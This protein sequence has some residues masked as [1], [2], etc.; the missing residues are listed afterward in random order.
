[1]KLFQVLIILLLFG[2]SL[3][4]AAGDHVFSVN[5]NK[6]YLNDTEIIVAGLRCSNALY[7]KTSTNDLI[8]HLDQYKSYGVNTV[9]VFI[10]GSRYGNF[11]G[12]LENGSLNP[13]HAKRL[14]KII[15]AADKRGMIVIV[16]C[17]YWGGSTAKWETWTQKDA[18]TAIAN[19]VKWL[20]DNNFRN[21]FI[22]VDNEGMAKRE[23]G[24]NTLE[25]VK[26]AKAI[27]SSFCVATNFKG[28][29]PK[30]ADLGIHFSAK[31]PAKPY[32][33]SEGTPTN[34]PGNYWGKYSK[35]PPLENYI[36]I[37]VYTDDMKSNQ[38][39][40]TKNH[41]KNGWGYM[42]A[43]TW[44]QCV[45][46]YG[47]NASPGGDG[48]IENPGIRWWLEALIEIKEELNIK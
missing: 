19:T 32:I 18:N 13:V 1:M 37:G 14:A 20:S 16:G 28:L 3:Y 22:D 25:L 27:D 33:E 35:A 8:N 17:L 46:P 9:S 23:A 2:W 41:F 31:D 12:Y 15:K 47:P 39:E 45:S 5:G 4:T 40:A 36:N 30:E 29:P 34:A 38:I 42:L 24:F 6:T 26:A 10:M 21:V 44:L 11:K 48:T 7:S 43:S